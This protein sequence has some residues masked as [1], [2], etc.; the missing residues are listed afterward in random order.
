LKPKDL[1]EQLL[2]EALKP[3]DLNAEGTLRMVRGPYPT[4]DAVELQN[5]AEVTFNGA[6]GWFAAVHLTEAER[7]ENF[8][9]RAQAEHGDWW[10]AYN[11]G[12]VDVDSFADRLLDKF[13][14]TYSIEPGS[15][16]AD[17]V[18][19]HIYAGLT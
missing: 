2:S 3:G 4:S 17:L 8:Y 15:N 9:D 13:L 18:Y 1:V 5:T 10:D 7:A 16:L 12:D 19:E 11:A 6:P 14:S